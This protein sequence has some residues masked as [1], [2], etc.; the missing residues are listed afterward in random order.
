M[1]G[2]LDRGRSLYPNLGEYPNDHHNPSEA[3]PP[4]V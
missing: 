4:A 3:S 1:E 2:A